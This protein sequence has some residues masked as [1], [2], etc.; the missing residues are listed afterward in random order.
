MIS[1]WKEVHAVGK[2]IFTLIM[3]KG[4]EGTISIVPTVPVGGSTY[5]WIALGYTFGL[6]LKK[7]AI[8]ATCILMTHLPPLHNWGWVKELNHSVTLIYIFSYLSN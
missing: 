4:D 8:R 1:D 5:A 3:Y 6:L 2:I 7:L